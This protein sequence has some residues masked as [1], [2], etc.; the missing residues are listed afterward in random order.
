M[1]MD[2][3]NQ[4]IAGASCAFEAEG[5]RGIGVDRVL[6]SSGASTRTLYKHFGSRDGLV[7]AVLDARHRT[8]MERLEA[9][10]EDG[11]PAGSLFAALRRW[12]EKRGARG[13]M[14]LRA[15][16]EYTAASEEIVTLVRRQKDEFRVEVSRRLEL[17]LGRVEETL[18]TQ[19]WLLFEGAMAGASVSDL[20]VVDKAAQAARSLIEGARNR[21]S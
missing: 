15:R 21:A 11:D 5:F 6:A 7:V 12:L 17:A 19:V 3:R 4:M 2:K 9:E 10:A 8:F 14:L 13:C 20:S 18:A 16:S 1:V